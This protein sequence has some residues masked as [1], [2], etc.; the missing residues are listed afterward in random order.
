MTRAEILA[1][2]AR[3]DPGAEVRFGNEGRIGVV[4]SPEMTRDGLDELMRAAPVAQVSFG[5]E[6]PLWADMVEAMR[7]QDTSRLPESMQ[8][9]PRYELDD[10]EEDGTFKSG[11]EPAGWGDRP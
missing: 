9:A 10:L 6:S 2:V 5:P 1:L 7:T 4:V 8:A 3:L 11:R